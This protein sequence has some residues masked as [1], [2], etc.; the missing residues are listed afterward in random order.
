MCIYKSDDIR[1]CSF[2]APVLAAYNIARREKASVS[3]S[4]AAPLHQ[5]CSFL[6]LPLTTYTIARQEKTCVATFTVAPVGW[7][8]QH[9][10]EG[11]AYGPRISRGV[12]GIGACLSHA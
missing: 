12:R 10:C 7:R 1:G 9:G 8:R 2:V 6:A 5:R 4:T 11:K 3:A